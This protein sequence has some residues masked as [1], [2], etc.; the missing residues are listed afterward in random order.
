MSDTHV[1]YMYMYMYN[2][3]TCSNAHVYIHV[4]V[5]IIFFLFFS[6]LRFVAGVIAQ[7]R[8]ATFE[9]VLWRACR[10]NVFMRQAP[11]IDPLEDPTTVCSC[12]YVH[13]HVH[14]HCVYMYMYI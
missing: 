4:H 11:I 9:R 10:G 1:L 6:L 8:L 13:V 14:V 12:L 2:T 5:L 3:C 7:E